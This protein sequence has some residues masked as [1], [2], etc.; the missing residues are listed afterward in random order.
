[1][2]LE[3]GQRSA[4]LAGR[5]AIW[6]QENT[7]A[8]LPRQP[9]PMEQ[10]WLNE[11]INGS[12][13]KVLAEAQAILR[14]RE[15]RTREEE[16]YQGAFQIHEGM[17]ARNAERIRQDQESIRRDTLV[18]NIYNDSSVSSLRER[19]SALGETR[20]RLLEE[21]DLGRDTTTELRQVDQALRDIDRQLAHI[22]QQGL[23]LKLGSS[24]AHAREML[25][26]SER[27]GTE[28]QQL[29]L[30]QQTEKLDL[31][32]AQ[33]ARRAQLD[34]AAISPEEHV[35]RSRALDARDRREQEALALRHAEDNITD[36]AARYSGIRGESYEGLVEKRNALRLSPQTQQVTQALRDIEQRIRQINTEELNIRVG[37]NAQ[38]RLREIREDLRHVTGDHARQQ[39]ER[40]AERIERAEATQ[41]ELGRY[42]RGFESG[43]ITRSQ[44]ERRRDRI[45]REAQEEEDRIALQYRQ[46][47]WATGR[48]D[49]ESGRDRGN[50]RGVYGN[51]AGD[52][53]LQYNISQAAFGIDDALQS[54]QYDGIRGAVRGASNNLTA[55]L[56]NTIVNPWVSATAVI[57]ASLASVL[58]PKLMETE[59]EAKK[60]EEALRRIASELDRIREGASISFSFT[61]GTSSSASEAQKEINKREL[62]IQRIKQ[63]ELKPLQDQMN[64]LGDLGPAGRPKTYMDA[65]QLNRERVAHTVEN[66]SRLSQ[67]ADSISFEDF[68]RQKASQVSSMD[69]RWKKTYEEQLD[70]P[71]LEQWYL[72]QAE[73]MRRETKR[74]TF[75]KLSE[76]RTKIQSKLAALEDDKAHHDAQVRAS[77]LRQMEL[78]LEDP[79]HTS[80]RI[81]QG[82]NTRLTP[83]EMYDGLADAHD[84]AARS[85]RQERQR[86][87]DTVEKSGGNLTQFDQETEEAY[88]AFEKSWRDMVRQKVDAAKDSLAKLGET[89]EE[90]DIFNNVL[91][92]ASRREFEHNFGKADDPGLVRLNA[93]DLYQQRRQSFEQETNRLAQDALA[94]GR[95][96]KQVAEWARQRMRK[97]DN[98]WHKWI[99]ERVDAVAALDLQQNPL[100]GK[101]LK[102]WLGK[103]KNSQFLASTGIQNLSDPNLRMHEDEQ[104]YW[105]QVQ[106]DEDSAKGMR[107]SLLKRFNSKK[108]MEAE[109]EQA[110]EKIDDMKIDLFDRIELKEATVAS[111][112]EDQR[113]SSTVR[114]TNSAVEAGSMRSL[115]LQQLNLNSTNPVVTALDKQL[116]ELRNIRDAI[117]KGRNLQPKIMVHIP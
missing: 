88:R 27:F 35:R 81:V 70:T 75:D 17:Q 64:A 14:E 28:A 72:T 104:Q 26:L 65:F 60:A 99:E 105:Q 84:E 13:Q 116:A 106:R 107:I 18:S 112:I 67:G 41:R 79:T 80:Q 97:F 3:A 87:R 63:T 57:G 92:S 101:D 52:R 59:D 2:A 5:G 36:N 21:Q 110:L 6:T 68:L 8:A 32:E 23:D 96:P 49:P 39:L 61:Q 12:N 113:N 7:P 86:A 66:A 48:F 22:N 62:E 82:L 20:T 89:A 111:A 114:S 4:S 83:D 30:R 73:E 56:S 1:M 47:D 33:A 102:E 98:D 76:E 69:P 16:G 117:Q 45:N 93:T 15:F 46:D 77:A 34:S 11:A 37:G 50:Q 29:S 9:T 91:D 31:A 43:R 38:Q 74:S 51:N 54:Y 44:Y 42:R 10:E 90:A 108:G 53:R 24:L 78:N 85:F 103:A 100:V 25:A 94:E 40:E 58:I 71:D 109:L 19:R 95:D 115:E 55:V